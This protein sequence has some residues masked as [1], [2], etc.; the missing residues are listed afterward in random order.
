MKDWLEQVC[1]DR[2]SLRDLAYEIEPLR[3]AFYLTGNDKIGDDLSAVIDE[4][5]R[6]EKSIGD[7][8][9]DNINEQVKKS[10]ESIGETI[11]AILSIRD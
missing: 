5:R 8:I 10:Q 4:I 11:K 1:D 9:A 3:S 2:K 7:A 6:A